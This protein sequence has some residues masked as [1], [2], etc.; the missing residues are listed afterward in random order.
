MTSV[1]DCG[2]SRLPL[3]ILGGFLGSGKTTLL[4]RTY[5]DPHAA[6]IVNDTGDR[7]PDL[8]AG[9]H[10]LLGGCACCDRLDAL[11]GLLRKLCEDRHLGTGPHRVVLETSG[12]ADPARILEA[13]EHDPILVSNVVI[14][15]VVIT[16]DA[17]RGVSD[18]VHEPLARAQ[19]EQADT[20]VVTKADLAGP[21]ALGVALATVASVNP[22]ARFQ[23]TA[24]GEARTVPPIDPDSAVELPATTTLEPPRSGWIPVPGTVDW[25]VLSLWLGALTVA[26]PQQILRV[27]GLLQTARGALILH[28][29]R[30]TVGVPTR[31]AGRVDEGE[32]GLLFVTRGLDPDMVARSWDAHRRAL[33]A[34]L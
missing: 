31:L 17:E 12:L 15:D 23:V 29:A 30:G 14:G 26:Y 19:V 10:A 27:K 7:S 20:V 1:P 33:S 9:V 34:D 16:V 18:L 11:V 24:F 8:V 25:T 28:A 5:L 2:D 21:E 4:E 3:T 6:I 22:G 13:V 32:L